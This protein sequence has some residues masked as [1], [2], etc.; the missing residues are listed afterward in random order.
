MGSSA[1][2]CH[3]PLLGN[4]EN[5]FEIALGIQLWETRNTQQAALATGT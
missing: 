5:L 2:V 1:T 3:Q 4:P